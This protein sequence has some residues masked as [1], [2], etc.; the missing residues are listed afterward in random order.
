MK[1]II[2][3]RTR[4]QA[5]WLDNYTNEEDCKKNSKLMK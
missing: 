5:S 1:I 3:V 4:H 2:A